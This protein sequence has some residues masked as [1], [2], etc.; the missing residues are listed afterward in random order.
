M[1]TYDWTIQS[2]CGPKVNRTSHNLGAFFFFNRHS[3]GEENEK[4]KI[5]KNEDNTTI[6]R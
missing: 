5:F 2:E 3:P 4:I 1:T 6:E